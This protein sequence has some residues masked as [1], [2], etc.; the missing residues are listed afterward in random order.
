MPRTLPDRLTRDFTGTMRLLLD[1]AFQDLLVKYPRKRDTFIVA[2]GT[3]DT[4]TTEWLIRDGDGKAL[5]PEDYLAMFARFVKENPAKIEAIR[6]LL[7]RPREWGTV[8]LTELRT[9][10]V[11][12][13]QRIH[14]RVLEK[15]HEV[16]YH[17]AL[18]D[19]ISMVKHAAHEEEPLL[20]AQERV[21]RAVDKLTAGKTFTPAQQ[22]WLDRIR[23]HL[24]ANLSIGQADFD[25]LPV[26]ARHGGWVKA[27]KD[28]G[29]KLV[30][31]LC[32]VNEAI[33]A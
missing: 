5:K 14:P 1:K 21:A 30:Q 10:L 15:A 29:G 22:A 19:I 16:H 31:F 26:F 28:F 7:D 20:T 6:I 4:V 11:Q 23:V 18:V 12:T 9:R 27:D 3:Q 13:R 24:E 32:E 2:L 17:K 25:D 8:A 33:A